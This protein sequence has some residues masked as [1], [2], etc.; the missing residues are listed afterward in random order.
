MIL[1]RCDI[2]CNLTFRPHAHLRRAARD[3]A[4]VTV[5]KVLCWGAG[6]A[7]AW[8]R[9]LRAGGLWRMA[10]GTQSWAQTQ[11]LG[12]ASARPGARC[13]SAQTQPAQGRNACYFFNPHVH[14]ADR[15]IA[16]AS[17]EQRWACPCLSSSVM[18]FSAIDWSQAPANARWWA[19]DGDGH[20]Y[21][22]CTPQIA[23]STTF[24]FA[25]RHPAPSFGYARDFRLSLQER[26]AAA[27]DT[28]PVRAAAGRLLR[29]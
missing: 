3:S 20:A 17:V 23:N 22:Y 14:A 10:P 27:E 26:P 5:R 2:S 18:N 16:R 7:H 28:A 11:A 25:S 1:D 29:R 19:I 15:P 12:C 8:R 13:P 24:W 4:K 6:R 9:S 21:W